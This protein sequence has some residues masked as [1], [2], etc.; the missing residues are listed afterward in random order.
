MWLWWTA[1]YLRSS[2]ERHRLKHGDK[3]CTLAIGDVVVIQYARLIY[4]YCISSIVHCELTLF[5]TLL[6]PVRIEMLECT[7]CDV[8][9][10]VKGINYFI[11]IFFLFLFNDISICG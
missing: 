8:T 4:I 5:A 2:R 11:C 1:E 10:A 3:K 6:S 7:S 9:S